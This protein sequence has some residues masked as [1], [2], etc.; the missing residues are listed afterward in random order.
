M[1]PN[2]VKIKL[3]DKLEM[4]LRPKQK[5]QQKTKKQK[6][7]IGYVNGLKEMEVLRNAKM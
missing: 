4:G 7:L 3:R 6:V 5:Y 2:A 1:T